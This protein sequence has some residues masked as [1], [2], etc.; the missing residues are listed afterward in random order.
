MKKFTSFLSLLLLFCGATTQA[1]AQV[2][3]SLTTAV[4]NSKAVTSL[5]AITEGD[6]VLYNNG[7][8]RYL[9]YNAVN[10]NMSV[11]S[12]IDVTSN[13]AGLYVFHITPKTTDGTTTY[14][15]RTALEGY[16]M[17]ETKT[18]ANSTPVATTA[19]EAY[20]FTIEELNATNHY[21]GIKT[22]NGV[23]FNG[24]PDDFVGW[25][26]NGTNSCFLIIPVTTSE[27]NAAVVT[28]QLVCESNTLSTQKY[29]K[30]LNT[31]FSSFISTTEI[32]KSNYFTLAL[33]DGTV[34]ADNYT[35]TVTATKGTAPVDF[36][37][38]YA[39]TTR[40]AAT[41]YIKADA[42]TT[43]SNNNTYTYVDCR[44][45]LL[46]S[47]S[48]YDD[49]NLS[50]WQFEESGLGVKIKNKQNGK[51]LNASEGGIVDATGTVFYFG[52]ANSGSDFTLNDGK[53]NTTYYYGSHKNSNAA[54]A[55]GWDNVAFGVWNNSAAATDGGSQFK[56]YA[57]DATADLLALGKTCAKNSPNT[58]DET[59]LTAG[60]DFTAMTSTI[61][62]A[63]TLAGLDAAYK[64]AIETVIPDVN[65]YYRIINCNSINNKYVTTANVNV[66]KDGTLLTAYNADNNMDR[67]LSR[68]EEGG[69]LVPQLFQ[70]VSDSNNSGAYF[71]RSAN[72]N[73]RLGITAG[74]A[75]DIPSQDA[76]ATTS[77]TLSANTTVQTG[78]DKFIKLQMKFDD[79][80]IINAYGG[81]DNTILQNWD[82]DSDEGGFWKFEK[83]TSIPVTIGETGFTGVCYPFA[84]QIPEGSNVK[85]YYGKE[86][87]DGAMLLTELTDGIIPANQGVILYNEGGST[88]VN[89]AITT[90]DETITNT[91]SGATARRINFDA[92]STYGLGKTSDGEV[93][94]MV[95]TATAVPANKPYIAKNTQSTS[96]ISLNFGTV[97]GID[98]TTTVDHSEKS[99]KYFDLNGRPVLYPV[100][101]LYI[102]DKGQKVLVP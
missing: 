87:T 75:V 15:I 46:S 98:A 7:R 2:F 84:V 4:D 61:D 68:V 63:T 17:P 3:K 54:H 92:S 101:G 102:T 89:L 76:N 22:S 97:D 47:A 14:S 99:V 81:N 73:I 62:A 39:M 48:T 45:S 13:E 44:Y 41:N 67:K 91:L 10:G 8:S 42:T 27:A 38:W 100:H 72:H 59:Y 94:F 64:A 86:L 31:S 24:N 30:E 33:E 78:S 74:N 11:S 58:A 96:A 85:A 26:G 29:I 77:V 88:S 55:G 66:D 28:R 51:Y 53:T 21:F 79:S 35:A 19:D 37:T 70:F 49:F 32:P 5:S 34:S 18:S 50:L 1:D 52:T 90:T 23:Y 36:G 95:N 12:S 80:H 60:T 43:T 57:V 40:D 65:A 82:S 6:Y 25:T 71:I 83:I 20:Q 16:Y 69:A 93:A 56:V 9:K